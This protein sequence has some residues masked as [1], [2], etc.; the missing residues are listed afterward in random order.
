MQE[1]L[2]MEPTE[3]NEQA[4]LTV[5]ECQRCGKGFV[6]TSTYTG[7]LTRHGLKVV[8]PVLCPTCMLNYGPWPKH[9]GTVKWFRSNKRYG[10]IESDAGEDVFFHQQQVV[11]HSRHAPGTGATVRFHV[12]ETW[13]G[14]EALNI[15]V[16]SRP[17]APVAE[18]SQA[19]Q[20]AA[21]E[22]AAE[23]Q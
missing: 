21:P 4:Q 22:Q 1:Q 11:N 2:T 23:Q 14:P 15:E 10:F 5:L 12:R 18:R 9:S 7:W 17:A 20:P 8:N 16:L 19:A 13:R 6:L 3:Q